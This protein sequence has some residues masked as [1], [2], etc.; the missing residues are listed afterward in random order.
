MKEI[1]GSYSRHLIFKCFVVSLTTW[2]VL[3]FLDFSISVILELENVSASTSFIALLM[4]LALEQFHKGMQYLESSVLIGTLI[5]LVLFNQQGNLVF[6]RSAG[7]S[8]MKLVAICGVG[9]MC[10]SLLL[11]T[12]DE[13]VFIDLAAKASIDAKAQSTQQDLIQTSWYFDGD[14][15]IG[16]QNLNS[17]AIESVRVIDFSADGSISSNQTLKDG[18]LKDGQI[19]FPSTPSNLK[20]QLTPLKI[21]KNLSG[22]SFKN[23]TLINLFTL[24]KD[25]QDNFQNSQLIKSSIYTKLLSPFSIMAIIFLAGSLM[26]SSSRS[27]GVGRQ[28]VL[29]ISI[30]LMYE[31]L[32]D[33]SLV[34]FLVYQWPVLIANLLPILIILSGGI[35]SFRRI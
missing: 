29:G 30:G 11:L 1:F 24:L 6:L 20:E 22:M 28:I 26:F 33:L 25:N 2:L 15:L 3:V 12:F 23:I 18:Q 19:T 4:S 7:F 17:T 5:A 9:P 14:S 13:F 27:G 10:L 31:L 32:K 16:I 21:E 35:Y 8:P 34:S